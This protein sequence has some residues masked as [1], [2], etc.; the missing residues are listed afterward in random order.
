M[1][2]HPFT[3][4]LFLLSLST[5]TANCLSNIY[6]PI[7]IPFIC[8]TFVMLT[9]TAHFAF[10]PLSLFDSSFHGFVWLHICFHGVSLSLSLSFSTDPPHPHFT[11]QNR[12]LPHS[13]IFLF[14][15]FQKFFCWKKCG[16]IYLHLVCVCV[17]IECLHFSCGLCVVGL[18]FRVGCLCGVWWLCRV[19][20]LYKL[21]ISS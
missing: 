16:M 7:Y 14:F 9:N 21:N 11:I 13:L 8:V 20:N 10:V 6:L 19:L 17:G 15:N 3:R 5:E 12:W 1:W 18:V 4:F 2:L